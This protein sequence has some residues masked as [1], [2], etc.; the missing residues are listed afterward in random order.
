MIKNNENDLLIAKIID[1]KNLC[2][3]K[4]RV[5]F[6]DFLNEKEQRVILKMQNFSNCFFLWW[7]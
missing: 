7:K 6:S 1:K 3:K 2:D 4:N 5:T